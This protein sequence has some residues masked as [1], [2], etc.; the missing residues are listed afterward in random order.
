MR[1]VDLLLAL[2]AL[3]LLAGCGYLGLLALLWRRPRPSQPQAGQAR[4]DVVVPAHD[5]AAG[6]AA[7]VESLLALDYPKEAFRVW[8]VADNCSDDTALRARQAGA[9][10][11]V[12]E[13]PTLRG[14]GHALGFAYQ[15]LLRDGFADALVVVD[16]D[17]RASPNLLTAFCA[18]LEGGAQAVQAYYGVSNPEASWRTRLM[19][20]AFVLFHEVR[21]SGR[22]RLGLSCGLRGN[23]MCFSRAVLQQ[24]PHQAFSLVEDLEYGIAL[25]RAGHRV[26]YAGEAWVKGEMV[27]GGKASVSQRHRWEGGRAAIA[28]LH[29]GPLLR[30]AFAWRDRVRADLAMDLLVP[31]LG[32]LGGVSAGLWT[33]AFALWLWTGHALSLGVLTFA[34]VSLGIYL[35]RG[36]QCAGGGLRAA[37]SLLWAPLY[38]GWKLLRVRGGAQPHSKWVRTA[39]GDEAA[40]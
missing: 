30:E 35:A 19:H 23:G 31:P 6:I 11:M 37:G 36:W 17:S 12:R 28:K 21:S 32:T 25:G 22:E 38:L 10:V 39:R 33:V 2:L 16:A 14:K 7:T 3:P 34:L 26:H 20:L 24:V 40:Q 1:G 15:A 8:V 5:E 27:P 4:F 18:R 13:D 9:E 29:L